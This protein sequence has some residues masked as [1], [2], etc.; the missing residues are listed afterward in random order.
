ME[1]SGGGG[2]EVV[3]RGGGGSVAGWRG[4]RPTRGPGE[5]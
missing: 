5:K 2:V 3:V 4:G 1:G